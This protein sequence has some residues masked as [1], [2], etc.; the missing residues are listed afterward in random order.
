MKFITPKFIV[1]SI[2]GLLLLIQIT[3]V[4][5]EVPTSEPVEAALIIL[6]TLGVKEWLDG[7]PDKIN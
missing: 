2:I 4:A 3:L 1:F 6:F 5:V 7:K